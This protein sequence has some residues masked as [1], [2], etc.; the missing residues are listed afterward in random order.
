MES[1]CN[2][3]REFV[4][5]TLR[6]ELEKELGD[7]MVTGHSLGGA[8]AAVC[9]LDIQNH[10]LSSINLELQTIHLKDQLHNSSAHA[11]MPRTLHISLYSYGAPKVGNR[12]FVQLYDAELPDSF[13]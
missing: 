5:T 13:R 7:V 9:A 1:Y 3:A 6:N 8:L 10:T 2:T 11:H 4:H 12:K